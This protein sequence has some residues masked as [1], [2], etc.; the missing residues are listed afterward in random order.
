MPPSSLRSRCLID[1]VNRNMF[2]SRDSSDEGAQGPTAKR[3]PPAPG[4]TDGGGGCGTAARGRV[5]VVAAAG[6]PLS[7]ASR[8]ID[9]PCSRRRT[10]GGHYLQ[11]PGEH[12]ARASRIRAPQW[13]DTRA[14][15]HTGAH[16]ISRRLPSATWLSGTRVTAAFT[17]S[18]ITHSIDYGPASWPTRT[19]FWSRPEPARSRPL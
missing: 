13:A 9:C 19:R 3:C 18:S 17:C 16:R 2:M 11:T 14:N 5:C 8:R 12:G 6:I 10:D 7:G 4:S 1:V 15:R